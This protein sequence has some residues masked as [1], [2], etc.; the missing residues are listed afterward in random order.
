MQTAGSGVT[1]ERRERGPFPVFNHDDTIERIFYQ[2]CCLKYDSTKSL[3]VGDYPEG[4]GGS[5]DKVKRRR[6]PVTR[7]D[8][9]MVPS[10]LSGQ[11]DR[12]LIRRLFSP[13]VV[14]RTTEPSS[15]HFPTLQVCPLHAP[16]RPSGHIPLGGWS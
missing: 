3:L 9:G 14:L 12:E 7:F 15:L 1:V 13:Q 8:L 10:Q 11:S 4:E 16:N 6:Q 2:E 5:S